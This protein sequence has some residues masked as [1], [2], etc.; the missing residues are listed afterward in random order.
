[1]FQ[2]TLYIIEYFIRS[3][4]GCLHPPLLLFDVENIQKDNRNRTTSYHLIFRDI[5]LRIII[6]QPIIIKSIIVKSLP[7]DHVH[8]NII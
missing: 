7:N 6:I 1:M 2:A 4:K 8:P 3:N 5:P